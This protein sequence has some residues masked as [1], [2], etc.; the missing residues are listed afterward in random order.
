MCATSRSFLSQQAVGQVNFQ[1]VSSQPHRIKRD[2]QQR[3]IE[4]VGKRRKW[5]TEKETSKETKSERKGQKETKGEY[6]GRGF[7][8]ASRQ[9]LAR[10]HFACLFY[11]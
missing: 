5:M 10:C 1:S 11:F 7:H 8:R 4:R 3:G 2:T 6:K 9:P